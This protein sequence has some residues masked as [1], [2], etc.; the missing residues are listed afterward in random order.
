MEIESWL[1]G[2]GYEGATYR[3]LFC[4]LMD[5]DTKWLAVQRQEASPSGNADDCD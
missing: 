5:L 4:L 2:H 3:E 1:R